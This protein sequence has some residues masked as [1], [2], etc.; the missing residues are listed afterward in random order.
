MRI[1][2]PMTMFTDY[3]LAALTLFFAAMMVRRDRS[4]PQISVR[5]WIGALVATAGASSFGATYHGFTRYLEPATQSMLWKG[6]VYSTGFV[7]LFM[8]SAATRASGNAPSSASAA[9]SAPST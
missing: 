6:T 1:T 8:L 5:L 3:A 2:E 4:Y 7:S 9:S